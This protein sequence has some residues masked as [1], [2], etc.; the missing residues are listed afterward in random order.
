MRIEICILSAMK[1][2]SGQKYCI[3]AL[4]HNA[5]QE[6]F[7]FEAQNIAFPSYELQYLG[8]KLQ[9][10]TWFAVRPQMLL[11]VKRQN[12]GS[13]TRAPPTGGKS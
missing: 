13:F 3:S 11:Y 12:L 4:G 1:P 2:V 7:M 6:F 9:V 5:A 8:V 10:D